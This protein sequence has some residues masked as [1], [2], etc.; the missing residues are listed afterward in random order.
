MKNNNIYWAIG[1]ATALAFIAMWYVWI[2]IPAQKSSEIQTFEQ[3]I[4]LY[5]AI[6]LQYPARCTTPD[7]RVFI[8]TA[9][10]IPTNMVGMANP[11]SVFCKENGGTLEIVDQELGQVGLCT[12]KSGKVCEEWSFFRG[13]CK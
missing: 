7:G 4:A 6:T 2:G 11:A 12:L 3:C 9:T 5:P 13:E 10:P 1:L 8:D